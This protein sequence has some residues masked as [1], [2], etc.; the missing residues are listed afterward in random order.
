[1]D[2]LRNLT[3]GITFEDNATR[4]LMRIEDTTDDIRDNFREMGVGLAGLSAGFSQ[5][6]I[7]GSGAMNDAERA[8]DDLKDE[9]GELNGQLGMLAVTSKTTFANMEDDIDDAEDEMEELGRE[10]NRT[11][12]KV[13]LLGT[14]LTAAFGGAVAA[15]APLLAGIGALVASFG[16]AGIGAAAF[17]AVA[18]GALTNIFETQKEIA[19]LQE[20]IEKADSAKERIKAQKE[21]AAIYADMSQE[22]QNALT[23]L[24]S[25]KTFWGG[26]V[27]QFEKPIFQTFANSL[28]GLQGVLTGLQPTIQNVAGVFVELTDEFNKS[29]DSPAMQRFFTWLETNAAESLYNFAHIF[30]NTFL[31][32]TNMFSAFAPLGASVEE[33]LVRITQRFEEWSAGLSQSTGFQKFVEYAKENGPILAD[34]LSNIWDIGVGLVKALAPLGSEVLKGLQSMTEYISVNVIPVIDSIA[35]K[36]A[37]FASTIRDNWGPIKETVI[38]LGTAF[39]TF[40]GI[41]LGMTIIG[42]INQLITAFRTGTLMA[43]I[44]QWGLNAAMLANPMTWV[45]A[46]IATLV[47]IG[48]LLYR[49]WDTIKAKAGELWASMRE[50]W[51]GIK[52]STSETWNNVKTSISNAMTSAKTKVSNFFSPLLEFLRSAKEKWDNFVGALK[53]F[54]MPKIGLPKWMGGKGL[55]QVPGHATGLS[56][57]PYDNYLMRAHKDET[58]L[59]ADQARALEQAGILDRSGHTPRINPLGTVPSASPNTYSGNTE[60]HNVFQITIYEAKDGKETARSIRAELEEFF[61]SINRISPRV[62][63]G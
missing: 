62:T 24:Q 10:T 20:K 22:Q 9:I 53:N 59:R 2:S 14:A 42:T 61:A 6:G 46:G 60:V 21:L 4:G 25:F 41:M 63:E 48:V 18:V 44:A 3:V 57:V 13:V 15:S 39:L 27:K 38:G 30:G 40:K 47:A 43:T 29:L 50:K 58:I 26:F 34:T 7:V 32:I 55:I 17:G 56:K 45:A 11:T 19:K 8:A 28:K 51:A 54:K 33:W 31:G 52:Q 36:A 23:A 5:V 49:N 1:M 35:E 12:A 37:G 16:A